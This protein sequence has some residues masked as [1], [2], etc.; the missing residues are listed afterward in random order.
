[1]IIKGSGFVDNIQ[2]FFSTVIHGMKMYCYYAKHRVIRG[3]VLTAN[4]DGKGRGLE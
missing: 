4:V 3:N 1:M 2:T